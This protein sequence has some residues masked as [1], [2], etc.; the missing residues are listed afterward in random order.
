ME[1]KERGTEM[2]R[3]KGEKA[4][5]TGIDCNDIENEVKLDTTTSV[6]G[7]AVVDSNSGS[8]SLK[9]SMKEA[10]SINWIGV[11]VFLG[12]NGDDTIH[13]VCDLGNVY[14]LKHARLMGAT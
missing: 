5:D 8:S 14:M 13:G 11:D 10:G 2:E 9:S 1:K 6:A 3:E 4:R 12:H 7:T